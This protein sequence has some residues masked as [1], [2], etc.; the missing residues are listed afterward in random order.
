[1]RKTFKLVRTEKKLTTTQKIRDYLRGK[2]IR[3][4]NSN[5][6]H[7]YGAP[8]TTLILDMTYATITTSSISRARP[9]GAGNT[10]SFQNFSVGPETIED[11]NEEI[12]NNK[13]R[14][15]E[16]NQEIKTCEMKIKYL[17]ET[18]S[19]EFDEMEYKAFNVLTVLEEANLTKLERAKLISELVSA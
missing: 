5:G 17:T 3:I 16:I 4:E 2:T 10:L 1:M 19:D 12:K 6:G 18:G 9:G 13:K 14:I 7:D 8:G 15:K 11:L